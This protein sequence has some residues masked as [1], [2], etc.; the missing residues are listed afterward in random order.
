MRVA[1]SAGDVLRASSGRVARL[2]NDT[3]EEIGNHRFMQDFTYSVFSIVAIAIHLIINF[4]LLM[5]RGIV[6][7]RGA[8]YRGFLMGVL[9]Y[10]MA[11]GAWG[12]FA[13][14]GWIG[15]WYVD[16]I[17]FFLS[18]ATFLFMW[19]RFVIT[20]LDLGK[21]PTRILI[22]SGYAL[23]AVNIA[24]LAANVFIDCIFHFDAKGKYVI[25]GLRDPLIYLLIAYNVLTA[26]VTLV[27]AIVSEDSVRRRS[28]MVLLFCA[29]IT[30]AMI[31]QVVWPLTP[32]TALGCLISNCFFNVF[33]VQDEQAVKH[34][35]E[36]EKALARAQAAEKSRSM[37]FSIVSHDIRTPLNAILGY[38]ELLQSGITNQAEKDEALQSIR[39]SGTTLLQLVNDVLDLAKMDAGKMTLRSEPVRLARLTDD[40]LASFKMV[41]AEKGIELVNKTT[42]VPTVMMDGHRLRQILFN[43]IGNAV[44]FTA[45]GSVSVIASYVG[46]KLEVAVSDTGCGIPPDMLTRILDPFVQIQDPSHAADRANG[47]GLGL[48]ICRS[49]VEAMGG[50][51][52]VESELGK[53]STFKANIPGVATAEDS[54]TEFSKTKDHGGDSPRTSNVPTFK[55]ILVVDDSPVNRSVLTAFLKKAGITSIGQ[56]CDGEEALSE[57]DSAIKTGNPYDFVFSDFWMPNMN[58]LE[59]IE[60]LRADSRY[61]HLPVFAVTADTEF[62]GDDRSKLFTGILLKPLTYG[63][64]ME[65]FASTVWNG[66]HS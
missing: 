19:C 11:D 31:L 37:F 52:I 63:K 56:A 32:F 40:V 61:K 49:L 12:V 45:H 64:L 43:L 30:A 46:T 4:N 33:V 39:A 24:L 6:T 50:E 59:L 36:L 25:D 3:P 53:G 42:D 57:L 58:G 7:A 18:L 28:L 60:K 38:S 9:F 13:E 2:A 34:A 20:Y 55:H 17:L 54:T 10:Y 51:L 47:T 16:T 15:P 29:T 23:L 48:S 41:A 14:L 27:K 22:W 1:T 44:K 62:H 21:C 5:G 66:H 65:T 35:I 8:R 26:I